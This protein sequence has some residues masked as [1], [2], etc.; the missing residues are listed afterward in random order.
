[1]PIHLLFIQKSH[2]SKGH[3]KVRVAMAQETRQGGDRPSEN[4]LQEKGSGA[5]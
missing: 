2:I 4:L 5:K 1:M 3:I